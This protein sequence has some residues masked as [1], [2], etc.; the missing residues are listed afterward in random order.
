M[1][2]TSRINCNTAIEAAMLKDLLEEQGIECQIWDETN[3]KVARGLLVDRSVDVM[4]REEDYEKAF[5]I[6]DKLRHEQAQGRVKWCPRC[7]S[8]NIQVTVQHKRFGNWVTFILGLGFLVLGLFLINE[9][10][11]QGFT[12]WSD[13]ILLVI[14]GI[15]LL[16]YW[17]CTSSS[18]YKYVCRD[19]K[20]RF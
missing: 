16:V 17:F 15:G 10:L 4:V 7:G 9:N 2:D 13:S 5:L 1:T 11:D 3:S 14:I 12:S 8:E 6:Y 19:C 20:Y 18:N